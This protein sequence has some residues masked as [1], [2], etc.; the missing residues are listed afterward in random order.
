MSTNVQA[1]RRLVSKFWV[2]STGV[3][4]LAHRIQSYLPLYCFEAGPAVTRISSTYLDTPNLDLYRD[5][6]LAP[7]HPHFL[8]RF[9]WYNRLGSGPVFIELKQR[10]LPGQPDFKRRFPVRPDAVHAFMRGACDLDLLAA[11]HAS[12][13]ERGRLQAYLDE[14][15]AFVAGRE[16]RPTVHVQCFRQS[17]QRSAEDGRVRLTLDTRLSMR[18]TRGGDPLSGFGG[19]VHYFPWAILEVKLQNERPAWLDELLREPGIEPAPRFS[20]YAHG[21]A[22]L[23]PVEDLALPVPAWTRVYT[24]GGTRRVAAPRLWATRWL[25]PAYSEG[26]DSPD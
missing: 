3:D 20:K 25:S 4:S 14:L 8:I 9:R 13:A 21:V 26:G 19:P 23:Y 24:L 17:F 2:H 18:P 7:Q 15:H 22:M 11:G 1:I 12:E 6:V 5:R 16:L 10:G